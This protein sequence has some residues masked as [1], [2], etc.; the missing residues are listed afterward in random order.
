M[1]NC[2][3]LS[4][5]TAVTLAAAPQL[6]GPLSCSVIRSTERHNVGISATS[7]PLFSDNRKCSRLTLQGPSLFIVARYDLESLAYLR[8]I[9]VEGS[10]WAHTPFPYGAW[11]RLQCQSCQWCCWGVDQKS[12]RAAEPHDQTYLELLWLRRKS[13]SSEQRVAGR[14]PAP[15][16]NV[17]KCPIGKTVLWESAV[18]MNK[19]D[20]S[21][22]ELWVDDKTRKA[23]YKSV[24]LPPSRELV[25]HFLT[26]LK[27]YVILSGC[28]RRGLGHFHKELSI[29]A[30][31]HWLNLLKSV[32]SL[33]N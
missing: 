33:N 6:T 18:R 32:N 23:Q 31:L 10:C 26:H 17:S 3:E 24:H 25:D 20:L 8:V 14:T 2:E 22:T 19:Y 5:S 16:E 27:L 12:R 15:P 4:R 11:E 21:C 29:G 9:H 13:G 30:R 7:S 28:K 1:S